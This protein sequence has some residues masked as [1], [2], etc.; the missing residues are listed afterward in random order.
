MAHFSSRSPS[1]DS[2][3]IPW[4]LTFVKSSQKTNLEQDDHNQ[5]EP[6]HFIRL[7]QAIN[8]AHFPFL[9]INVELLQ[10]QFLPDLDLRTHKRLAERLNI[11]LIYPPAITSFPVTDLT[12][13]S[14]LSGCMSFLNLLSN[15]PAHFCFASVLDA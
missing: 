2:S 8:S 3:G 7:P 1:V 5:I 13:M 9:R 4:K 12:K 15:R 6:P 14:R 11:K 10:N